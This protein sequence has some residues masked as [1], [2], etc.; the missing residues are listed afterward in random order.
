VPSL[1][2]LL[3][4]SYLGLGSVSGTELVLDLG[5][6]LVLDSG[7][8]SLRILFIIEYQ[9]FWYFCVLSLS[10]CLARGGVVLRVYL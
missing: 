2:G 7:S 8:G 1:L 6:E 5:L 10:F 4:V 9:S 3:V